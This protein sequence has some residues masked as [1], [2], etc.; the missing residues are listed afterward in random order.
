S[1]R[2]AAPRP[3]QLPADVS[4]F[5]GRISDLTRLDALLAAG[6]SAG[7]VVVAAIVGTAGLGKSAL[8]VHWA[9]RV[10]ERFPDGQLHVNLRGYAPTAPVRPLDALAR[11]LRALGVAP[12]AIPTE[13]DA[14]VTLYRSI[15][16]G[17]RVLVVLDNASTADQIRPLLPANPASVALVTSRDQLSELV[18]GDGAHRLTLDR[19]TAD[20]AVELLARIL[21][22][23]R[24]GADDH[25]AELARLCAYLPLALRIA[26]ANLADQPSLAV[27][28]YVAKLRGGDRL[29]AL[30]IE[31]DPRAA[32]RATID[33]SYAARPEPVRRLLRLLALAPGPDVTPESAAAVADLD[34]STAEQ[35]LGRLAGAHLLERPAPGRFAF[36]D[37]LRLYATERAEAEETEGERAAASR[38]LHDHY[39]HTVDAAAALLYPEKLRLPLPPRP[40][41]VRVTGFAD[42]A[43]ASSWMEA[44]RANLVAVVRHAPPADAWLLADALRGYFWLR[45]N[46][47]DWLVVANAALAAGEADA[48]PHARAAA[49]LSLGDAHWHTGRHREAI[50][51]YTASLALSQKSGSLA[52]QSATL[53]NLAGVNW[54][55]GEVKL[56]A[57]QLQRCLIIDRQLGRHGGLAAVQSNLAVCYLQLGRLTDVLDL[58]AQALVSDRE[59]NSLVG[60]ASTHN[61]FGEVYC[62]LGRFTEAMTHLDRALEIVRAVDDRFT[63]SV[64]GVNVAAVHRFL[65]RHRDGMDSGRA[66]LASAQETGDPRLVADALNI[67]AAIGSDCGRHDEAI[68]RYREVVRTARLHGLQFQR[69]AAFI[70]LA[71]THARLGDTGRARECLDEVLD[72]AGV[73]GYRLCEGVG[74]T[75]LGQLDLAAGAVMDAAERVERAVAIHR[76]TGH[77]P[78][79]ARALLVLG[80]ALAGGGR[81]RD[82]QAAWQ[83]ALA[84]FTAMGMPEAGVARALVR[85]TALT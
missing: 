10:R 74:L 21:G 47:V 55:I 26:A 30:Q 28:D 42:H 40:P 83:R 33:L 9:H 19:L 6:E 63:E 37:L 84:L 79:E 48:A 56:A 41:G 53:N 14:A 70:G 64:V 65:G 8:A 68:E 80:E 75:M 69:I 20:E 46:T 17:K 27:A 77:R 78:G 3:A 22:A 58:L 5:T 32:V 54:Q 25:G 71:Q 60:E 4:V 45:V 85:V 23:E 76:E 82:A 49:H 44:E 67:V 16:T 39:L 66:A 1:G 34:T 62:H 35:L 57:A 61:N 50:E 36:H 18:D 51:H 72:V 11:F 13:L 59:L 12:D 38:R 81:E 7:A 43:V 52:A 29:T 2:Q 24:L 31:G 15:L 73:V